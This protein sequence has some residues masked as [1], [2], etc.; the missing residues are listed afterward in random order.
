MKAYEDMTAGEKR[1]A[2][3]A[4]CEEASRTIATWPQWKQ[5]AAREQL[6]CPSTCKVPREPVVNYGDYF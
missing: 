4:V 6:E 5:D 1:D 3:L 2:L